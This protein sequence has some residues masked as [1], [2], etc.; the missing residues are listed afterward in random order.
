LFPQ[1]E[2]LPQGQ[3]FLDKCKEAG[4]S[5]GQLLSAPGKLAGNVKMVSTAP[6][7]LQGLLTTIS[8]TASDL[9]EAIEAQA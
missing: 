2:G 1:V 8:T 6:A 7:V 3:E 9:K 5:P 4:L